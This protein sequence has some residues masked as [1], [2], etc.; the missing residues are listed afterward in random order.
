M[1]R[2][3]KYGEAA[4]VF[5]DVDRLAWKADSAKAPDMEL[6]VHS[7]SAHQNPALSRACRI[8]LLENSAFMSENEI[9]SRIVRR[10]SFTFT[11]A[12]MAPVALANELNTLIERGLARCIEMGNE[13]RWQRAI[14]AG[15]VES[16][17]G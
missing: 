15:D 9:Y 1:K 2:L 14:L 13:R 5:V 8:A 3:V 10:G 11:N 17:L 12:R 16:L 7:H 4:E 6:N